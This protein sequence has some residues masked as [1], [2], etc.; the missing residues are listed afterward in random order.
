MCMIITAQFT[1]SKSAINRNLMGHKMAAS[2]E[3]KS[4]RGKI[5]LAA[6]SLVMLIV[7]PQGHAW[8]FEPIVSVSLGDSPRT[9]EGR[10]NFPD[11]TVLTLVL[12][13]PESRFVDTVDVTRYM[14]HLGL[15]LSL[16]HSPMSPGIYRIEIMTSGRGQPVSVQKILGRNNA[17]LTG[18]NITTMVWPTYD[19][20]TR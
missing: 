20:K 19:L 10:T 11:G 13:R 3:K 14:G 2:D 15:D 6:F 9:V 4:G 8:A 16:S 5:S 7:L 1:K 17:N 18:S 12:Y